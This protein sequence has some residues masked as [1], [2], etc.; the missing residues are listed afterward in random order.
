MGI[1]SESLRD[2]RYKKKKWKTGTCQL[3]NCKSTQVNNCNLCRYFYCEKHISKHRESCSFGI[4]T[5]CQCEI[6]GMKCYHYD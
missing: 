6:V 4:K 1:Y 5:P 3:T 2:I